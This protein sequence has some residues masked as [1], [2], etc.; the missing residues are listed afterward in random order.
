MSIVSLNLGASENDGA[1]QNLRS[2]G[3]VINANFAELDQ[4]TLTAQATAD[5]AAGSAADA[6][7]QASS[8]QAK[9]DA[10]IPATQKGQPDGVATLDSSGVVPASQL[11]SYVDDVLEF[12]SAA[13]FPVTGETGKIYVAINTNSQYRWSGSQYIQ[14]SASP[15]STDAV[16]EG[17]VNKYWTN[18]R[19]VASVLAG[20][21]TTNPAVVAATDSILAAIGKLQRQISDALATLGNKATNGANGDITSLSGLTTAL[22][23]AQGGTGAKSLAAAQAALGINTAINLPAGTDLNN[24]QATGFYMQQANANASLVLNYPVAA[25]GSLVG[26]QLGSAITT[27]T[28]TVYNTGEQ[29]VRSRYVAVWSDWRLTITDATVGFAY[30]YPNGGTEAAPATITINTRYTVANPF[31]G[32]EVIVL[33]EILIGGKWGDAGW[34]YSSGGYGTKGSQLDLNTLVVQTGAT[35]VSYTSNASGDPF[36]QTATGLSSATCRLKVWRVHA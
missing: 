16:P 35:R 30:A 7:A 22:S 20:L 25:A 10:A 24:I 32:H 33:A 9:A 19:T 6:G 36:G 15:G 18:A 21:V 14:L 28:Y 29:Y 26:V 8:A 17:S 3:Q 31:P 23:I 11:P 2:G 4:R 13:A 27:Q 1:G 5:A 12:A 34:F